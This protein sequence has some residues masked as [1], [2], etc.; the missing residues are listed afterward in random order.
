MS[1]YI[2]KATD[3]KIY[4]GSTTRQIRKRQGE[5]RS[6]CFNPARAS[7]N[8]KPYQHFRSLGMTEEDIKCEVIVKCDPTINLLATE[9]KWIKHIGSLNSKSSIED[10][11][12]NKIRQ[13]KYRVKGKIIQKCMCGGTWTYGHSARHYKTFL[14]QDWLEDEHQKKL[15]YLNSINAS[16]EIVKT[17][18]L[19]YDQEKKCF[20]KEGNGVQNPTGGQGLHD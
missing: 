12:K 20:I 3:D 13:E 5:H 15:I 14:H 18:P 6:E 16:K 4:V 2:I 17:I 10:L 9:A 8:S 7:Y 11:E 1:V 19:H